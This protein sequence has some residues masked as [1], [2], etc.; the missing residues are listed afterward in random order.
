MHADWLAELLSNS[1]PELSPCFELELF[2]R[3]NEHLDDDRISRTVT[4]PRQELNLAQ[5]DF[6]SCLLLV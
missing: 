4:D 1:S 5:F 2:D 6:V 3:K